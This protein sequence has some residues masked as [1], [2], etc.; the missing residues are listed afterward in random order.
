VALYT[1]RLTSVHVMKK[2]EAKMNIFGRGLAAR[3]LT[4]SAQASN[5]IFVYMYGDLN[6]LDHE[7]T[8][9]VKEFGR[10]FNAEELCYMAVEKLEISPLVA[11]LF[12][13]AYPYLLTP[14]LWCRP[15][16]KITCCEEYAHEFILRVRFIP[17]ESA[18]VRL[19]HI[20]VKMFNYLFLQIRSD[21]I[22]DQIAFK[23]EKS[24][25][26][27]HL[28]GLGVIDM[29]RYGKEHGIKL[30]DLRNLEPHDFIPTSTRSKFNKFFFDK[31]RLH[32]NF[33][34]HLEKQ[35]EQYLNDNVVTTQKT[36]IDSIMDYSDHY[37]METFRI[38]HVSKGAETVVEVK[39]YDSSFPGL[40]IYEDK[41]IWSGLPF[42]LF[43]CIFAVCLVLN[44]WN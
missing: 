25:G 6:S 42:Y 4:V 20:D 9:I 2:A 23:K 27:E 10:T 24:I 37:G 32:M 8:M 43:Y 19:I 15:N 17:P 26:Q 22:N 35:Y 5:G 3:H 28:L 16:E 39:P 30:S 41:V 44:F 1:F 18:I 12:A 11:P 36:Y 34:P 29:V 13:L 31:K 7:Q 14:E 38:M 33:K 21:F 40:N